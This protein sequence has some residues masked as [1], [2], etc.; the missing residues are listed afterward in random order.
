[1]N[2]HLTKL[3][4]KLRNIL[5]LNKTQLPDPILEDPY[6]KHRS[7]KGTRVNRVG[8]RRLR[9]PPCVPGTMTHFDYIVKKFG[10][11]RRRADAAYAHWRKTGDTSVFE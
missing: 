9:K 3:F 11:D 1:M 5:G 2:R 4:A 7:R 10:Y 8:K 6:K